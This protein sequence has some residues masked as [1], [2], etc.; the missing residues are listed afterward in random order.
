MGYL[1]R[2]EGARYAARM[3]DLKNASRDE[4]IWLVIAQHE[5]IARQECI[6]ASQQERIAALE[7][8]V[9]QLTMRVGELLAALTAIHDETAGGTGR[10]QGMPGLKPAPAQPRPPKKTRKRREQPF[11]RHRMEPTQ[12][13]IH[14]V[15]Q[16]PT[17][18]LLLTGGSVKRTREVIEV[19]LVPAV[20]T[21]HLFLE[22]CCPHCHTRH[23]AA[24]DLGE[25]VVGK[26]RFGV[27]LV[28]LIAT[29]R[30]EARLP[31]ATI[32]WYLTTVHS[33]SVSVGAIVGA[34]TQVAQAGAAAVD[35]IREEIRGSPVAH[36]D[37]TGW[38]ENG[39]NGYVW[40]FCT[41][42]AQYFTRGSRAGAMVD[43]VLGEAFAGVLVSDFYVGY[44][45]YPGVKQKCWAHL[46]RDI[47]DLRVAHTDDA[48]VQAWAAAVHDLYVRAVAWKEAHAADGAAARQQAE[49]VF[50][51][52]LQ[53]IDAPYTEARVPQRVLSARM[54]KH[55]HELFV[56]V[57]ESA[58]PPD[59]NEAER[60][61]RHMV[62][63]R[64]ISGGTRST[65][66]SETKMTLA[67]LF[68][69]WRRI[70]INPFRACRALLVSP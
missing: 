27:G 25:A 38:R 43:A 36:G 49:R 14:V 33:L 13:V 32:Q 59:N 52:E 39:V 68:G 21:E 55:S 5:T 4:L 62:T 11:V 61:L 12:R 1:F 30:E 40:T 8:T 16:C 23:T 2:D 35:A 45:H 44:Q 9:A 7:A 19:P 58:V 28:S 24:V 10:P 69:T 57:R 20:V 66:G 51:A 54:A 64:K 67:T 31:V 22:R 37:E 53:A 34:L 26:Q 18:G 56:F 60:A 42:T 46:L 50:M 65:R 48:D 47:H 41:P 3:I 63:S 17:C 6:I 29:L 15:E 70:G